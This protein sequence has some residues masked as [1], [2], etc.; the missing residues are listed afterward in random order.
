MEHQATVS[1]A[2]TSIPGPTERNMA[3]TKKNSASTS[4]FSF[5]NLKIWQRLAIGFGLVLA[6][7][8]IENI[9]IETIQIRIEH[10]VEDIVADN[11]KK[12][13]LLETM[14]ESVHIVSRVVRS[15]LLLKD[16][17]A[18]AERQ[19]KKIFEARAA[20]D[21]AWMELQKLPASAEGQKLRGE[22]AKAATEA[23]DAN[24]RV[25]DLATQGKYD[26]AIRLLLTEAR[27]EVE[28][29]QETVDSYTTFQR[30]ENQESYEQ[31]KK[32]FTFAE[33]MTLVMGLGAFVISLIVAW[34]NARSIT[35]P[36]KTL[37]DM[38]DRVRGGD[39][40]ALQQIL[41]KDE[42]GELGRSVNQI[43]E[44]QI[45]LF[46]KAEADKDLADTGRRKAE[47]ENEALNNDVVNLLQAV[48]QVAQR[49]LTVH[50][51]VAEGIMGP[52]ADSLNS[53]TE[54][55]AKVLNNV[56]RIAG[57]VE[58]VS[59]KVR[60]QADEV[61]KVAAE[62]RQGVQQMIDN[63]A[64]AVDH[65]T[66]VAELVNG[67]NQAAKEATESTD[68]ALERVGGTV[69]G[70][71]GIRETIA[72]TEK[73]IKRLGE[74]SQEI[75]GIVSLIN[76]ISERTHVLALNAAMQAAIA[77]E[78][79]RGFAVV[80]EEVQRLAESSQNATAQIETLVGNI[81][82]ET[83]ETIAT[84]NKT[85]DQV[86]EGSA[87]AQMAGEQMEKTQQI[88]ANL[89]GLVQKISVGAETQK[90]IAA[91][92][93]QRVAHIGRSTEK[94]AAQVEAQVLE[95]KTLSDAAKALVQAVGAFKLPKETT[96]TR[97]LR[98]AA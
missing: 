40:S 98:K 68:A 19:R 58:D 67:T 41:R 12:I 76:K 33:I 53:L 24:N 80:A 36:L 63:L 75:G 54:E 90:K 14:S 15:V 45:V 42:L 79:G 47:A 21:K 32:D 8:V 39:S 48:H 71:D 46:R 6:L 70:M 88:T 55:T 51:P 26:A 57:R 69:K 43:L 11:F 38:I 27:A 37:Q 89:A 64:K 2:V 23:R 86:V 94:T 3:T 77:G 22:I 87:A 16:D 92:L 34:Y 25:L 73:R 60:G 85:I 18:E 13:E 56:A 50:A 28:H 95:T 93:Q 61:H 7:L 9:L 72:E 17:P 96:D 84:M 10:E 5:E 1:A 59:Q 35:K 65:M 29:W 31:I 91:H 82:I 66:Q 74:R 4:R 49:D 97:S 62:E 78:A 30:R 81:R 83:N 44:D 52:V 20:Y